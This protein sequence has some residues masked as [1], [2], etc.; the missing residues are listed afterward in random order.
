[1]SPINENNTND[2][3]VFE[4]KEQ[5]FALPLYQIEKSIPV[6]EITPLVNA[7][8]I[9]IGV[10][11]YFGTITPIADL[12][13]K[14]GNPQKSI[15]LDQ[16]IIITNTTKRKIGLL[17]NSIHNIQTINKDNILLTPVKSYLGDQI[18]GV[19][20]TENEVVMIYDLE[21]LLSLEEEEIMDNSI[22]DF[23]K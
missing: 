1:M 8:E 13:I 14:F 11:N 19:A 15:Q 4:L 16:K 21:Q 5:L 6:I 7:P 23:R 18:L 12:N 17:V 10:I 3:L 20:K 22:L 9:I 2:Y